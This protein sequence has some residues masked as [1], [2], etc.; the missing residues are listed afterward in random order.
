MAASTSKKSKGLTTKASDILLNAGMMFPT[1]KDKRW[2]DL[3]E[4]QRATVVKELEQTEAKDQA[5]TM[6]VLIKSNREPMPDLGS[7]I[8]WDVE[9]AEFKE[10]PYPS[11]YLQPFHSSIGGWLSVSAAMNNRRAMEAIYTDCHPQ[12]CCG[13]RAEIAKLTPADARV[14]VDFGSGDGDGPAEVARHLPAARVIA[15]EASP[16][17]TIVGRRQNRDV[18]NLEWRHA[19]AEATGL[20]TGSVDCV[21]IT[22][23]FHEC[24]DEGKRAIISEAHR[25]L[26]PGGSLV[27]SDTPP[28]DLQTYRGFF[29]P[30]KDQWLKFDVD[31]FL[32]SAGFGD[33]RA[34]DVTAPPADGGFQVRPTEQRLFTRV[35]KKPAA[36]L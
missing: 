27:F 11:Y 20:E 8:D 25:L 34:Y 22:L 9:L 19:L 13:M 30:W 5:R 15:V 6:Q 21:T 24:S 17:M 28:A 16:F 36:K 14:V 23:V 31:S 35:A 12:K 32:A 4:S 3:W 29:E 18:P 2:V 1:P 26:R 33:L 10:L 7:D